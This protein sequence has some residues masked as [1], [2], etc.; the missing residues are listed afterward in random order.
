MLIDVQRVLQ[1]ALASD[2]PLEVLRRE[3]AGLSPEDRT[4]IERIESDG[5]RI[6]SFL[7]RKLRFE[8]ICRGDNAVEEWFDRDPARV[9]DLFRDFNRDVPPLAVFPREEAVAFHSYLKARGLSV[10]ISRDSD[11]APGV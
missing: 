4:Q 5:F 8:R 10:P 9:T 1:Q 2:A 3:A 11:A 7:V 6:A